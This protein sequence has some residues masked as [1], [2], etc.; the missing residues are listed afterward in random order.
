[1][2]AV[3]LSIVF[4]YHYFSLIFFSLCGMRNR[5]VLVAHRVDNKREEDVLFQRT[6]IVQ[7][8]VKERIER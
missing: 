4:L 5:V 3:L 7:T 2:S 6:D 1:M 8:S